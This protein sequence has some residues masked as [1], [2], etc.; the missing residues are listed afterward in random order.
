M[1]ATKQ[2]ETRF[3]EL[4]DKLR[5]MKLSGMAEAL[6]A[7]SE[8]ANLGLRPPLEI[9][10]RIIENEWEQRNE[11]KFN[12]F[13]KN[14]MLKYPSASFDER[15]SAPE[16]RIDLM[17]IQQLSECNWIDEGRNLTV[18]GM[19]GT[20]KTYLVC[21]L[22]LCAIRKF[23]DVRYIKASTLINEYAAA[24][25]EGKSLS[26]ANK[27]ISHDLLII[28]DFGFMSLNNDDCLFIFEI[29]DGRSARKS[30]V[31]A[32]QLPREN[33]YDLFSDNTY[34]D[35]CMD[36]LTKGAYKIELFGPSLRG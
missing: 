16:R 18:T 35:A 30:T 34:A 19:T 20:G 5:K 10:S 3:Y 22:A 17:A 24:K 13:L 27:M 8:D 9:L 1:N 12:R 25:M 2:D 31:V 32:S 14:A 21:A 29:L 33:W 11:K 23:Y 7:F 26:Y 15:L 4:S 36:R 6:E 28:D